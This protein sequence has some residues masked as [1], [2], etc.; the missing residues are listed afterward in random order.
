[1]WTASRP[2][3]ERFELAGER[4]RPV[5]REVIEDRVA[6]A[7]EKA[8]RFRRNDVRAG[9]DD[10]DVVGEG[11]ASGDA[12]LALGGVDTLDLGD[13][14]F[15]LL[16]QELRAVLEELLRGVRAERNEQE[17]G[18]VVVGRV[19]VDDGDSPERRVEPPAEEVGHDRAACAGAEDDDPFHGF[20]PLHELDAIRF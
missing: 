15:D 7:V 20:D 19:A 8:W 16:G 12:D 9:R 17:S 14:E 2:G 13:D 10:E 6:P 18:L 11:L 1:M 5:D 3:L 4:G